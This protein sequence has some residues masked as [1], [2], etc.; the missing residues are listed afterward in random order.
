[1]PDTITN[2]P[3]CGSW[4]P[5]VPLCVKVRNFDIQWYR[6]S[7]VEVLVNYLR[8]RDCHR[9]WVAKMLKAGA[10][11]INYFGDNPLFEDEPPFLDRRR[12]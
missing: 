12:R 6:G 11:A 2:Q 5:P 7:P 10:P 9:G 8:V 3:E 4:A 1:M